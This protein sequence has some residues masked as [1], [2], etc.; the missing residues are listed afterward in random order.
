MR[1]FFCLVTSPRLY[2]DSYIDL[3]SLPAL[4]TLVIRGCLWS[5]RSCDQ[6]LNA[7]SWLVTVLGKISPINMLRQIHL[8]LFLVAIDYTDI[9]RSGL[10]KA[11]WDDLIWVL[12]RL[13]QS[14][15]V[16]LSV[17]FAPI[18]ALYV[19]DTL[20][21]RLAPLTGLVKTMLYLEANSYSESSD[22]SGEDL[23]HYCFLTF[24][25]LTN[26]SL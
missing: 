7:F 25:S 16:T 2:N 15:C 10:A 22:S 13:A 8:D 12:L 26:I 19:V 18:P 17:S 24:I 9:S 6:K 14:S 5:L 11:R 4:Q 3:A 20:K 1:S 21:E 23:V